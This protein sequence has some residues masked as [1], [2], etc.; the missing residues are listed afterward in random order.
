MIKEWK[1]IS[2]MHSITVTKCCVSTARVV[3]SSNSKSL[4][5]LR[6]LRMGLKLKANA[7]ITII[8]SFQNNRC[9]PYELRRSSYAHYIVIDSR[10]KK[11]ATLKW[12]PCTTPCCVMRRV[13]S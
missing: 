12:Q 2:I 13:K 3:F 8:L 7:E 5:L 6:L 4:L 11:L 1:H 9:V 10:T